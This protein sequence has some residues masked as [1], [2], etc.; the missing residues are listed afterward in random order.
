[1][2]TLVLAAVAVAAA[3]TIGAPAAAAPMPEFP[4][5]DET[6]FTEPSGDRVL[7]L[8]TTVDAPVR[9]VWRAFC[10]EDG[11]K[12]FAVKMAKVD[13]RQGGIIET[14]YDAAAEPGRPGN[15]RNL[16]LAIVPGRWLVIRNVQAPPGFAHAEEFGRTIT[17]LRFLPE[18]SGRTR[19]DI[20]AVGYHRDPAFDDL[21][22]KFRMGDAWTLDELRKRFAGT[23]AGANPAPAPSA[24]MAAYPHVSDA[25][26]ADGDGARTIRQ[27]VTVHAPAAVLWK[28]FTDSA[29]YSAWG[30]PVAEITPGLG[31]HM[32]VVLDPGRRL[33]DP[34]NLRHEILA[35]I[36]ERLLVFR[37][38]QAPPGLPGAEVFGDTR[39]VLEFEDLGDDDTR[40]TLSQT[41]YE[42]GAAFD[43]LW[44]FF[45]PHNAEMLEAL[46]THFDSAHRPEG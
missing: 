30:A 20:W 34:A 33:G 12:S 37:N 5:I 36:P 27:S 7:A 15:I 29:A 25:S 24:A 6:S 26:S 35:Y 9:D 21:F 10:T 44:G 1:M 32:E 4:T 41:G 31:G 13:F 42:K 17:A 39:I 8:S 19:V 14:S 43:A 3:L 22:S 46:K 16:I 28:A 38:V 2:K 11:W 18:G 23:A 40:V 45:H